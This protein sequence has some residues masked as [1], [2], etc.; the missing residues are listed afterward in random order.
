VE[1]A[2][3]ARKREETAPSRDEIVRDILHRA[4]ANPTW[5]ALADA[6]IAYAGE[7]DGWETV[8]GAA[9]ATYFHSAR[10]G[11]EGHMGQWVAAVMARAGI[12]APAA[13]PTPKT[14]RPKRDKPVVKAT[15]LT[16][17]P[18]NPLDDEEITAWLDK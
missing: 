11:F 7:S 9:S 14:P 8:A 1:D 2:V 5:E 18:A 4:G 10:A 16:V 13:A 17:E 3:A 15:K 6:A 12:K